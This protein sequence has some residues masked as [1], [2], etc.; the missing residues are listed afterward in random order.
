MSVFVRSTIVHVYL[1]KISK[2]QRLIARNCR[3]R[4]KLE[5][6]VDRVQLKMVQRTIA[7]NQFM[8]ADLIEFSVEPC[9]VLNMLM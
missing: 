2:V 5:F 8:A 7:V 6:K 9:D 1:C 4:F 3:F